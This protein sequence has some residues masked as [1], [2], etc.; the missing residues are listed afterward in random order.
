MSTS[1]SSDIPSGLNSSRFHLLGGHSTRPKVVIFMQT[2]QRYLSGS[3]LLNDVMAPKLPR[4]PS[5]AGTNSGLPSSTSFCLA[6]TLCPISCAPAQALMIRTWTAPQ[7]YI[8]GW[9]QHRCA[10]VLCKGSKTALPVSHERCIGL[11]MGNRR[12]LY[13]G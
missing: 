10:L 13:L 4:K 12:V 8:S 6:A 3:V 7:I 5:P 2:L 9:P 1:A 11:E